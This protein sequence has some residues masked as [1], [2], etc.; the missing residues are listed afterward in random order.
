MSSEMERHAQ[1]AGHSNHRRGAVETSVLYII[2]MCEAIE[3]MM[4]SWFNMV[5]L[6]KR[7]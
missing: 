1:S 4:N 3:F 2:H 6:S 7:K 5:F